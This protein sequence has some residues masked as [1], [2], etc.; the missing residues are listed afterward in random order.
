MR[1]RPHQ[2][3]W[4]CHDDRHRAAGLA[5]IIAARGDLILYRGGKHGESATAFNALA[6]GLAIGACQP[7]G[8][9]FAGQ[10]WCTD[11][12]ACEAVLIPGKRQEHA[13]ARHTTLPRGVDNNEGPRSGPQEQEDDDDAHHR[14]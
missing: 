12:A 10:H 2:C 13:V 8:V 9:T 7:G 5:G 14:I 11:H 4:K 3:H 6:E 1:I